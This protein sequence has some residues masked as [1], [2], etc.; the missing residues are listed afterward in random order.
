M[1]CRQLG[2]ARKAGALRCSMLNTVFLCFAVVPLPSHSDPAI[3][4]KA[5]PSGDTAA[6]AFS[7]RK[8]AKG[9]SVSSGM[10][11]WFHGEL[12][13]PRQPQHPYARRSQL[14][15]LNSQVP[16]AWQACTIFYVRV[17]LRCFFD[18][19]AVHLLSLFSCLQMSMALTLARRHFQ[20]QPPSRTAWMR[21]T[22]TPRVQVSAT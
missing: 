2:L 8:N 20:A 6:S 12:L 21:A 3:A 11:S 17:V 22:M 7:K 1:R 16:D 14:L 10:Y 15:A 13:C 4:W 19:S 5:G 18:P 9:K